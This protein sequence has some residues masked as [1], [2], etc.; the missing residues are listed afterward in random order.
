[1]ISKACPTRST[2]SS[3]SPGAAASTSIRSPTWTFS[4]VIAEKVGETSLSSLTRMTNV[5]SVAGSFALFSFPKDVLADAICKQF[6]SKPKVVEMNIIAVDAIYDYVT[7]NFQRSFGYD[8]G[9]AEQDGEKRI[10]IRGSSVIGIG[11]IAAG[12]RL[13]TYYP[14]TPASDES[15]YLEAHESLE[16]EGIIGAEVATARRAPS[17]SCRPRTR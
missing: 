4:K 16:L 13:Q 1:M 17:R 10:L 7:E 3:R 12:C 15:E 9:L 11:K 2:E 6:K 14:I 8:L 5:M